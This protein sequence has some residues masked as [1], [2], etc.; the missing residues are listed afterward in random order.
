MPTLNIGATANS[1][2][3]FDI[4][5]NI[6]WSVASSELWLTAN[7]TS[8]SNNGNIT[9]TAQANPTALTRTAT[10]TLSGSGATSQTIVVTQAAGPVVL[11]VSVPTLNIDAT[12]NSTAT[13]D[14]TSNIAWSVASSEL[15]LT[16]NPASGSN[17]GNI[18]LTAQANPTVSTRTATITV[19]GSGATSQTIVVTQAAGS[20]VLTVSVQTLSIGNVINL[21]NTFDITSNIAW[22]VNSNETWLTA[23]IASG[24]DN[25]TITLTA[26]PNTSTSSR[27]ATVTVSGI[28][29][30]SQTITV[31]QDAYVAPLITIDVDNQNVPSTPGSVQFFVTCPVAWTAVSDATWCTITL[32]KAD[33]TIVVSYEENTGEARVANITITAAAPYNSTTKVITVSQSAFN[34]IDD[35]LVNNILM[36][37][38]PTDGLFTIKFENNTNQQFNNVEIIDFS[39]KLIKQF[40]DLST[41]QLTIDLGS[42]AV[43]VYFVKIKSTTGISVQKIIKK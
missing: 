12:A 11:T 30:T 13:F 24:S 43:G 27:T 26:E 23:N 7:P 19:S 29:V 9:L 38:N 42:Y 15:W 16:A 28:G 22:S 14:I 18:T 40:N 41:N 8:G 37:P 35:I 32:T 36:Y 33:G 1:T 5:S 21:T 20:A 6:A 34:A 31:T 3:L 17:N 4:T 25:A 10:I 2:A 39:G